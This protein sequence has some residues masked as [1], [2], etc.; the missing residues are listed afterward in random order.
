MVPR[1]SS[2]HP[3]LKAHSVY[4][5]H[6][7]QGASDHLFLFSIELLKAVRFKIIE[8]YSDSLLAPE[9]RRIFLRRW[10]AEWETAL[11]I[12]C[13]EIRKPLMIHKLNGT[14]A[15]TRHSGPSR[16]QA[17]L[18]NLSFK[19]RLWSVNFWIRLRAAFR[20]ASRVAQSKS[21]DDRSSIRTSDS[22]L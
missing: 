3:Y 17:F 7:T 19:S 4:V 22:W 1:A 20:Q 6:E 2:G 15:L 21:D 10:P 18:I 8:K 12:L 9:T 11:R 5:S 16:A 13:P 14:P